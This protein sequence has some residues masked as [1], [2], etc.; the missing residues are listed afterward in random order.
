MCVQY[1]DDIGSAV[2]LGVVDFFL[3]P[4][5]NK[6]SR[7]Q[8]VAETKSREVAQCFENFSELKVAGTKSHGTKSPGNLMSQEIQKLKV[9]GTNCRG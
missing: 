7:E 4:Y 6:K 9:A 2:R 5:W 8:K 3:L 1:H